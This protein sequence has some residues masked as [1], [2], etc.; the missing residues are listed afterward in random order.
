M[1]KNIDVGK[2]HCTKG[3]IKLQAQY[4]QPQLLSSQLGTVGIWGG[5]SILLFFRKKK[6][7]AHLYEDFSS[8]FPLIQEAVSEM[9]FVGSLILMIQVFQMIVSE[10]GFALCMQRKIKISS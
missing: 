5:G 9:G 1:K 7:Y 6:N 4:E 8:L 2:F 3:N 10:M